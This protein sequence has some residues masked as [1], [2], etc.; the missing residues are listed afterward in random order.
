MDGGEKSIVLIRTEQSPENAPVHREVT[1]IS[2]K[3]VFRKGQVIYSD[4]LMYDNVQETRTSCLNSLSDVR[5][6]NRDPINL[7]SNTQDPM[8][9]V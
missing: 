9:F 7:S 3:K 8:S 6:V 2:T 1:H 4:F 5:D